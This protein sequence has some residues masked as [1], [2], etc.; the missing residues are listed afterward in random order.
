MSR[1][2]TAEVPATEMPCS[3]LLVTDGLEH[4]AVGVEPEGREISRV[5]LRK[6]LWLM[7]SLA[8]LLL[9]PLEDGTYRIAGRDNEREVLQSGS[10][11]GVLSVCKCRVEEQVRARLAVCRSV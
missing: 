7:H 9:R 8:A 4:D 3:A 11:S 10:V 2:D 6:L 1:W 5:I